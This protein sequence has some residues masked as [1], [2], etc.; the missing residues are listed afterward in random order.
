M[1]KAHFR[2]LFSNGKDAFTKEKWV[3]LFDTTLNFTW[4]FPPVKLRIM[5][6]IRGFE[7]EDFTRKIIVF[8]WKKLNQLDLRNNPFRLRNYHFWFEELSFSLEKDRF[9]C[10]IDSIFSPIGIEFPIRTE[11]RTLKWNFFRGKRNF[12]KGKRNFSKLNWISSKWI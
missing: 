12:F 1:K 2:T 11:F 4:D 3:S 10:L 8:N 6:W 5:K 7:L 9:N